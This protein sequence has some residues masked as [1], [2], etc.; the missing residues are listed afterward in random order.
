MEKRTLLLGTYD[1]AVYG[2]TLASCVITKAQQV[3]TFVPVPGRYAPL[4]LSTVPTDGQPYYDSASLDAVLECSEGDR[5]HRQEL[6]SVLI[7]YVDG[8]SLQIVHPDHP[9][10]YLVGRIQA[11]QEYSDPA[12]CAVRISA[13]C[14]PWLY[15]VDET[16]ITLVASATKKETTIEIHGRLAVV[17]TV[18]VTGEASLTFEGKTWALS[19]G[20]HI[21]PDLFLTP[22]E[23]PDDPAAHTLIYSGSGTI[24]LSFREAVLAA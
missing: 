2:W 13:I 10:H 20:E 3:Q 7:N 24:S 6:I 9:N 11:T 23:L 4:D 22:R 1:S 12:H 15:E 19:K 18:T 21:L 8:R 5:E 14:E 16:T 17:P